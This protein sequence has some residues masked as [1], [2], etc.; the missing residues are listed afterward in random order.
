MAELAGVPKSWEVPAAGA[1][2]LEPQSG[3]ELANDAQ[4]DGRV[5]DDGSSDTLVE[6]VAVEKPNGD[7]AKD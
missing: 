1:G 3:G 7:A 5:S 6:T 2:V 4:M